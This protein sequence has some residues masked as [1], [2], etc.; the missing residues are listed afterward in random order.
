VD[1]TAKYNF[2]NFCKYLFKCNIYKKLFLVL[3]PDI[4]TVRQDVIMRSRNEILYVQDFELKKVFEI[5][6]LYLMRFLEVFQK[7]EK[8]K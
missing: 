1:Y 6:I 4:P 7:R 2:K 5:Y 8:L 3:N